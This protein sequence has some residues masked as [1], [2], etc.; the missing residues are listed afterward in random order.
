[1]S[2]DLTFCCGLAV[3]AWPWFLVATCGAALAAEAVELTVVEPQG[4]PRRGEPVTFAVPFP[5]R[6]A[7]KSGR[8]GSG[9]HLKDFT[10]ADGLVSIP[11]EAWLQYAWP[12]KGDVY[13]CFQVHSANGAMHGNVFMTTERNQ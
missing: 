9:A 13:T 11:G 3:C 2:R 6:C 8:V 12:E 7:A 4:M 10:G 1:M 5:Q